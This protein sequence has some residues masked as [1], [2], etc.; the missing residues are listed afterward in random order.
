MLEEMEISK[1]LLSLIE[2]VSNKLCRVVPEFRIVTVVGMERLLGE[3]GI[4]PGEQ[5]L[6]FILSI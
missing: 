6:N 2:R 5:A 4:V 3:V 1:C